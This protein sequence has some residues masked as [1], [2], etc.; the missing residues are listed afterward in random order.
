VQDYESQF[1]AHRWLLS[2]GWESNW[3]VG[4][5][6][7]GC[8]VFDTWFGPNRYRFETFSDTDLLNQDHETGHYDISKHELDMW[9]DKPPDS[10][11]D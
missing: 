9:S 5:H 2:K 1:V 4:R 6:P 8:H 10:Y 3:G 11:F 7:L